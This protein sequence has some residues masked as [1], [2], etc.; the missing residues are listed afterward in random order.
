[1]S[2]NNK[3]KIMARG[4][5]FDKKTQGLKPILFYLVKRKTGKGTYFDIV[6]SGE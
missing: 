4:L 2:K 5:V 3:D 1:M 6:K